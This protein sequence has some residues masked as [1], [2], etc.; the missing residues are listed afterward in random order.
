MGG[1]ADRAR[2]D[3][4]S[5]S[6]PGPSRHLGPFTA[7]ALV[8]A[9]MVG[10]GV[11][12]TSGFALADLGSPAR[13]VL[14]WLVGGVIA[15]LGALCYGALAARLSESGGEYLFLA[16]T[17]HPGVGFVAG[18]IS[19]LAGFTAPIAAAAA[20]FEVYLAPWLP[21]GLPPRLAGTAAIVG[22]GVLHGL[23]RRPGVAFQNVV[24]T[25]KLAL[26]LGLICFGLPAVLGAPGGGA[27]A[28]ASARPTP[29]FSLS[30]F[31][32]T[33]VWISLSYSG[34]NAAVYV[35]GEVRD[36]RRNLPRSLLWGTL[37]VT[38]FYVLLNIVFV[39]SAPVAEL[40]GRADVA[41]V[42]AS[43]LGGPVLERGV[44]AVIALALLTSISANVMAGPRVYARMAADGM[45]WRIF[46]QGRD[47]PTAAV[48]LQVVLATA[49]LWMSEL[50]QLLGYI[51]Y[52]LSLSTA[53]TVVG[54]VR[55]RRR[56]GAQR[57]PIP[58]YPWVP[59][60]FVAAT[61]AVGGFMMLRSP[62]APAMGLA[63]VAAGALA[64]RFFRRGPPSSGQ[65]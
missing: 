53:A 50:E 3:D 2:G 23:R 41:A 8:V 12:T 33:L 39:Y 56:E 13:V 32:V 10:V 25:I 42:A 24:V 37:L 55:L 48:V 14:A 27:S 7:T 51:G 54:L 20:G 49:V 58:G 31:S 26:L 1:S 43:A 59:L 47:A 45:F 9:S 60:A 62:R 35:G 34:W 57:V 11:F 18:W 44:R 4:S 63:T 40:E 29:G 38:A 5:A 52:T 30:A 6:G 15:I 16:R 46:A 61:L 17:I 28:G 64:Y 65:A 36:P 22:A 21:E 19:L